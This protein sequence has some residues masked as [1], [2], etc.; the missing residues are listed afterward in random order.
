MAVS[1][2]ACLFPLSCTALEQFLWFQ[3][4]SLRLAATTT[5]CALH[6]AIECCLNSSYPFASPVPLGGRTKI[7]LF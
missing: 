4:P 2:P 1:I 5:P 3:A 7:S 6:K